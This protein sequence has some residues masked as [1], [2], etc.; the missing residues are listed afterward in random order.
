M[1]DNDIKVNYLEFDLTDM[2]QNNDI[3]ML[4]R[5]LSSPIR[6]EIMRLLI[7][8]PLLVSEISHI[9]GL[10]LSSASFH[11]KALEDANLIT[12][13]YSTKGKN[14]LKYYSYSTHKKIILKTRKLKNDEVVTPPYTFYMN[15][16]DFVDASFGSLCGMASDTMQFMGN[17]PEDAFLNE[18][19]NAQIIW[20]S[21]AGYLSYAFPNSYSVNKNLES[22]EF[23]LEI[24]SEAYGYNH[25]FPSDITFSINNVELYTWT[26]QGDYGDHYGKYTPSWWF[27][28]STKYGDLVSISIRKDG[29]YFNGKIV[30]KDVTLSKLNLSNGNK[31]NFKIEVKEDARH[32]GGFNVFGEK[33][34]NYNQP[35]KMVATYSN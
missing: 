10:Q 14:S 7:K 18:R 9:L 33:F 35:I 30:N 8:K 15:I 19:H 29:V 24:C 20:N 17:S 34:G 5:A 31:T 2:S 3:A 32:C 21:K 11:L 16:G 12:S 25:N 22:L 28:E 23:S 13:H 27:I 4:G 26:C 6:L 1:D